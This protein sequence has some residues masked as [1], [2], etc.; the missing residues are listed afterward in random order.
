MRGSGKIWMLTNELRL[1][2]EWYS[3]L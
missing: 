2:G 1:V 3:D